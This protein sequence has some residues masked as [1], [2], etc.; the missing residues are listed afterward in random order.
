MLAVQDRHLNSVSTKPSAGQTEGLSSAIAVIELYYPK[1]AAGR[2]FALA[3]RIVLARVRRGFNLRACGAC[4][5]SNGK[6]T[7]FA[8]T[9]HAL[10]SDFVS[11]VL[12][13][14]EGLLQ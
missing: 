10:I 13:V 7:K 5:Q 12:W 3:R 11:E 14:G 4:I 8:S 2:A 9:E 6:L 1:K